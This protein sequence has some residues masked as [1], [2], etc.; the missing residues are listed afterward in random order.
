MSR[1]SSWSRVLLGAALACVAATSA[2]AAPPRAV[3]VARATQI[4]A[5]EVFVDA[6]ARRGDGSA[7][8]PFRR[9]AE[10]IEAARPGAV[11]CVAEGVYREKLAPGTKPFTL[12]GG[13]QRGT[14]F[15]VRDSAAFVSKALGDGRGSFL[16]IEDPGPSGDELTAIDGF[17]IT[18]YSQA[19]VR[20]IYFPQQFSLTN[21]FIHDNVCADG[22]GAGAGFFFNNVSGVVTRN[23]FARNSCGRGGAGALND[24]TNSNTLAIRNNLFEDNA[25]TEVQISHGGALYL[26]GNRLS[27]SGNLFTGNDATGWGG[28]LYVGAFTGGGQRTTARLD[29]NVYRDNRAGIRGGGLFCDDSARCFSEHEIYDSNCGGNIYLDGGPNGSGPTIAEFNQLTNYGALEVGCDAPGPGVVI[30][31]NNGAPD[32]YA[33]TN[34]IFR[35]NATRRDFEAS[36]DVG[37][38][39]L[40]VRV[41][42]SLVQKKTS[43]GAPVT[44]GAGILKPQNPLFVSP[45]RGDFHLRSTNGHWTRNG[46]VADEADSPALAKGDPASPTDD[47]PARAGDRAELGAYGNSEQASY[48]E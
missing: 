7:A 44:F 17:E 14:R 12:A 34:A 35:G 20:D 11:I 26:F 47:N 18:G 38:G 5:C 29:W 33:F 9:I 42:Y 23:V 45:A 27:I 6:A 32:S 10:A 31:K 40:S 13:F 8:K 48:V 19:V 1:M 46:Y 16:R 22:A 36:C 41:T 3:K 43:G 39:A 37:C 25:G 21:N 28:G 2:S 15:A 4:P 24:S 30:T